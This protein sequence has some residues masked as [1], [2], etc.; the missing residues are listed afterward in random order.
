MTDT[1]T[2]NKPSVVLADDH[3]IVRSGVRLV[4]E[5]AGM[6]VVAEAGDADAAMR[7]VSRH[8]PDVLVLDL[9]MPGRSGLAAVPEI[10]RISP[11]TRVVVLTMQSGTAFAREAL[12]SGAS[13][14]VLK[15]AADTELVDAIHAACR[16]ET[17]LHPALGARLAAEPPLPA[18]DRQGLTDREVGI[19]ELIALGYTNA[20]IAEMLF[21]SVRTIETH[22]RNVQRKTGCK[23]RAALVRYAT[24]HRLVHPPV[25]A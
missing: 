4:L 6:E 9:T 15:E 12:R 25:Q 20:E 16:G 3:A 17:Y 7:C 2:S 18:P 1:T 14:Y 11:A 8:R 10:A 21:L 19:L 23:S 13:A 22:R 5:D 24:S